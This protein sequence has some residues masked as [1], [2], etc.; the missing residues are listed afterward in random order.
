M[1]RNKCTAYHTEIQ[2][3]RSCMPVLNGD[4]LHVDLHLNARSGPPEV[5][6]C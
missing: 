5:H 2:V 3:S 4:M 1:I 6:G